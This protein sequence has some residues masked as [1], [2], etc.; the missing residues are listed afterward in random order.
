MLARAAPGERK[1]IDR[2]LERGP[3]MRA[4]E[5]SGLRAHLEFP[6]YTGPKEH[7]IALDAAL[8]VHL[9]AWTTTNGTED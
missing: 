9:G 6:G 3:Y 7:L 2:L 8:A 5:H 1:N 4:A